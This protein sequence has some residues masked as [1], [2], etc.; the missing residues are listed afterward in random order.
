M[1]EGVP[2]GAG[3]DQ[4]FPQPDRVETFLA[5]A[6]PDVDDPDSFLPDFDFSSFL[7]NRRTMAPAVVPIVPAFSRASVY[8]IRAPPV[9]RQSNLAD[10]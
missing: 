6:Y 7:S 4:V 3:E 5:G 1:A 2:A 8:S 10:L 9:T